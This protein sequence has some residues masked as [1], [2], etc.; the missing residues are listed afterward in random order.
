MMTEV[1]EMNIGKAMAGVGENMGHGKINFPP[2]CSL[3]EDR[4]EVEEGGWREALISGG[5]HL[6]R[7]L[8]EYVEMGF[9]C[10]LEK[11]DSRDIDGCTECYKTAGH[12]IYRIYVRSKRE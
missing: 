10:L 3:L 4:R 1:Y 9:E 12:D 7:V 2:H 8:D 11:L 5:D 6:K